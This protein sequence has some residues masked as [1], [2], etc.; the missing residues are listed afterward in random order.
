M[1]RSNKLVTKR[2]YFKQIDPKVGVQYYARIWFCSS[3]KHA[4]KG[5]ITYTF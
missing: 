3:V 1:I 2:K 5:H 4:S